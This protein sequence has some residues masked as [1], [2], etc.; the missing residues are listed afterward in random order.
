MQCTVTMTTI[1]KKQK[2]LIVDDDPITVLLLNEL[3]G[4]DHELHFAADEAKVLDG[5][6]ENQGPEDE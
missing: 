5:D 4:S 2:I 6:D 1:D 3:L